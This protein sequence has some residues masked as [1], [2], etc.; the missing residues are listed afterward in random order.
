VKILES[1]VGSSIFSLLPFAVR[2]FHRMRPLVKVATVAGLFLGA[3]YA[4]M[5]T[6]FA[7]YIEECRKVAQINIGKLGEESI[8]PL[9]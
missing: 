2:E 6:Y 4:Q 1:S 5:R 9:E 8:L 7:E 3:N